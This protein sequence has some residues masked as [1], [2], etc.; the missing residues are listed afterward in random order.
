VLSL[1][2]VPEVRAIFKGF[3]IRGI[4]MPYTAQKAAG[5]RFKEV[6]ITNF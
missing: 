3:R 4:I 2:D 5:M 6:L 1:N